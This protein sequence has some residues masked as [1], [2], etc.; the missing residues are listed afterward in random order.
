LTGLIW[1]S[2]GDIIGCEPL[3]QKLGGFPS[4]EMSLKKFKDVAELIDNNREG[5]K[6]SE[7]H[8]ESQ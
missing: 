1:L 5:F 3:A 6:F 2:K 8:V 7:E 4:D